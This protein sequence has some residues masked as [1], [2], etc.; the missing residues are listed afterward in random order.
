MNETMPPSAIRTRFDIPRTANIIPLGAAGGFS[1]AKFW[2]VETIDEVFCLRRW[3]KEHPDRDR[4]EWIHRVMQHVTING[5]AAVEQLQ[6]T[7]ENAG[8]GTYLEYDGFFWQL[9]EWMPGEADFC[10]EPSESRLANAMETL[11]RF[12]MAA[13]Q[14]NLDFGHSSNIKSRF[15]MLQRFDD[16]MSITGSCG[17]R[18]GMNDFAHRVVKPLEH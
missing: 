6:P 2:Q 5:C 8:G 1:G 14:V 12:H 11:A 13:A 7:R 18:I 16:S 15:D 10:N 9:T 3:P 4:L 17:K